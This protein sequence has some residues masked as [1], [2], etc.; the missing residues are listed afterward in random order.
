MLIFLRA[1]I[2]LEGGDTASSQKN[3]NE[4]NFGDGSRQP[5]ERAAREHP[6][7]RELEKQM[8]TVRG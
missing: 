1:K 4:M 8:K 5:D 6:Q 2:L 7:H 3:R